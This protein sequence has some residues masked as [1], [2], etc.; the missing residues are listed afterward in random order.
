MLLHKAC[1]SVAYLEAQDAQQNCPSAPPLREQLHRLTAVLLRSVHPELMTA[2]CSSI[3]QVHIASGQANVALTLLLLV[4]FCDLHHV[5]C[6]ID[7]G[8]GCRQDV[9]VLQPNFPV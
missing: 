3:I 4:Q 8:L 9:K 6:D 2:L 7:Q 5:T 1:L